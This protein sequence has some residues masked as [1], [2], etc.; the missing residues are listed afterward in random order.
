MAGKGKRRVNESGNVLLLILVAVALFA[1]VSYAVTSSS[2][3][4]GNVEDESAI[5]SSVEIALYPAMIR[6]AAVRMIAKGNNAES[7]LF[8]IPSD[9]DSLP[10]TALGVFHPDG[11]GAT[12][13]FP[14]H[15]VTSV[16][17]TRWHFN[18][19]VEIENV[20]TNV[21]ASEAGNE[22]TAFLPN[23]NPAV[24]LKFNEM[25]G[26]TDTIPATTISAAD[27]AK[28][29]EDLTAANP[30][31]ND[32]VV[33]GPSAGNGTD[34]F[35]GLPEGCFHANGVNYYYQVLIER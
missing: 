7:L 18:G 12:H 13:Q 31:P 35:N 3:G 20:G 4:A 33:I 5:L 26:I 1:A 19:N 27:A 24:C 32:E 11:G 15:K 14:T 23:V 10:D 21:A 9:F 30:I 25:A 8:N 22:I 29:T 16:P 17:G 6:T 34:V 28:F 2:R